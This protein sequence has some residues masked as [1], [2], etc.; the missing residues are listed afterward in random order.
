MALDE[1]AASLYAWD[2]ADEGIKR[3]LDNLEGRAEVNSAYLIGVMHKE[4]RPL[5]QRHYPHNPVRKYYTP[6]DSRTYWIPDASCY[7]HTPIKPLTT[8]REFLKGVDWLD[9]LIEEARG[10][11]MKTGCEVSHTI[12]DADVARAEYPEVLQ[13]DIY[14][15]IVGAR[16]SKG[17]NRAL[18]CLNNEAVQGYLIGLFDDITKNH[19]VDYVQTCLVL[20]GAGYARFDPGAMGVDP[21]SAEWQRVM[22]VATGGC[23]CPACEA[24]A[25]AEGLDW[26]A[27]RREARHL[28]D[29]AYMSELEDL[30]EH[31][32]LLGTNLTAAALI[33]EN[34]NFAAW[35]QFRVRSVTAV[36]ER[37][38]SGVVEIRASTCDGMG[39][40]TGEVQRDRHRTA[41]RRRR[42]G[43]SHDA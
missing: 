2:L 8:D 13:R 23:F 4:K 39:A 29:V 41:V 17:A 43:F 5:H 7:E 15:G 42:T 37:I 19:D 6:E 10:R 34:P 18:P 12:I 28:A 9:T 30:H 16:E 25:T 24:K 31:Q 1:I 22:N 26:D 11:G 32:M 36:F 33:L 40:G 21:G 3:C 20:F 35:L 38:R 27:V 14:G